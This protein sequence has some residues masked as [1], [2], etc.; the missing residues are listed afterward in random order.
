MV[1]GLL[2]GIWAVRYKGSSI[3]WLFNVMWVVVLY[4]GC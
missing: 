3:C 4:V 1:C 2:N